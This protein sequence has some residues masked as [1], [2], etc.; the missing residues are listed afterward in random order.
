MGKLLHRRKAFRGE[1][2]PLDLPG[3]LLWLDADD[4]STITDTANLVDQWDDKSGNANH[5]TST[6]A[7][8]PS[9]GVRTINSLNVIDF[10]GTE[11]ME[12]ADALGLTGNPDI[13]I[14]LILDA[15]QLFQTN[16]PLHV[17]ASGAG[18]GKLISVAADGSFRF[19]DGNQVFASMG[20]V[21]ISV[22]FQRSS[23][24]AYGD[25]LLWFDNVAQTETATGNPTYTPNLTD[26]LTVLGSGLDTAGGITYEYNGAI[27]QVIV[28][29]A[30]LSETDRSNLDT[31]NAK[32]G[33]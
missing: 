10:D 4:A 32:W 20:S 26:L 33:V 5:L 29:N 7:L 19:N 22:L 9:T 17:G 27:G 15:D 3:L 1:W 30:V 6:L 16:R 21:D 2:S 8:R 31:Y 13:Y 14:S 24:D 18:A 11:Y 25:G 12:R 28:G 23:G